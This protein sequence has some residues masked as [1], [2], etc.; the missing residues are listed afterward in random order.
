MTDEGFGS[1]GLKINQALRL[2]NF[3]HS[4]LC[5][6]FQLIIIN[7][8]AEQLRLAFEL[9]DHVLTIVDIYKH[10]KFHAIYSCSVEF[11]HEN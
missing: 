8:N 2:L 3:V 10:G 7:K 1:G 6:E 5:M 4:Q 11:E 9:S